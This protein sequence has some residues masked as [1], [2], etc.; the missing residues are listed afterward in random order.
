MTQPGRQRA[1]PR[2]RD[3]VALMRYRLRRTWGVRIGRVSAI[4]VT[5]TFVAVAF[6]LHE[7]DGA[8]SSLTGL[9]PR[10]ARWLTWLAAGPALLSAA[11][12]RGVADRADGVDAL[13]MS[14]GASFRSVVSARTVATMVEAALLI[15][16]PAVLI[17][18]V[19]TALAGSP[20][21]AVARLLTTLLVVG[22]AGAAGA[23]LGVV[24]NLSSRFGGARGRSL[25]AAVILV[26]WI[27]A[28]VGGH[29][30]WS[31]PGALDAVLVAIEQLVR[32]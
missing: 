25:F 5:G 31:I 23:V 2:P 6:A 29:G 15:A 19:A 21:Q 12:A 20:R 3:L 16:V 27:I 26:P 28:D 9:V 7:A 13:A 22:F 18:L 17:G 4:V 24:A 30:P 11:N 14:R 1:V 8:L 10:S 32:G